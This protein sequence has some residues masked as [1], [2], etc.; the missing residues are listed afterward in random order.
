M[1]FQIVDIGR[2]YPGKIRDFA[3][4]RNSFLDRLIHNDEYILY[5]DSD[6]EASQMLLEHLQQLEPTMPWYDIRQIN[7][8]NGVYQPL[9]NPFFTGVLVSRKAVWVGKIHEKVYPR[10]PHGRI[11]LPLIHNH[12]GPDKYPNRHPPRLLLA[13]KKMNE[14][15]RH[16]Y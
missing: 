8:R 1:N 6:V 2:D 7:Y 11:D 15:L 5:K 12:I 16:G 13:M 10:N 4:A 9:E 3:E 14:I